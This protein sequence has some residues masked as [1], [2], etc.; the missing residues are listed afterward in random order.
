MK[1]AVVGTR[2]FTNFS[3]FIVKLKYHNPK[4][5]DDEIT[6]LVSGGAEGIDSLA[7]R[8]AKELNKP[9][10]IFFPDYSKYGKIAPLIRNQEIVDYADGC[11]AFPS[12]WSK[13]T[14]DAIKKFEKAKKPVQIVSLTDESFCQDWY[15]AK[16]CEHP[17]AKEKQRKEGTRNFPI[18][19]PR[20]RL[21]AY[22][23]DPNDNRKEPIEGGYFHYRD[24]ALKVG[25]LIK[26]HY[27]FYI[28]PPIEIRI[29]EPENY[30]ILI[31]SI[32]EK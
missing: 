15:K 24:D 6:E 25:E 21:L 32:N 27:S 26:K 17:D 12:Y 18:P 3:Q 10:K 2:K 28:S 23:G 14:M 4:V 13:G 29:E 9:I 20:Y 16:G 7:E 11:I 22:F 1:L 19:P 31:G 30:E 5:F 8:L